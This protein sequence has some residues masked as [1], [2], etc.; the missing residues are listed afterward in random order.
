M[1]PNVGVEFV[2]SKPPTGGDA[3]LG[4]VEFAMF[5][6]LD[7]QDLPDNCMANAETMGCW[8]ARAGIRD[9]R[10]HGNQGD[11]RRRRSR[12]RGALEVVRRLGLLQAGANHDRSGTSPP[13]PAIGLPRQR[14]SP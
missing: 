4:I 5:P 10:S 13:R 11:K 9:R 3:G 12:L 7:H 8:P 1:A 14:S 6:H 2:G